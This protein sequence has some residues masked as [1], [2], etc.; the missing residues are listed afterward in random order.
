[1]LAKLF[2][3]IS[4]LV[5]VSFLSTTFAWSFGTSRASDVKPSQDEI[6]E[7]MKALTLSVRSADSDH[8]RKV[9][10]FSPESQSLP[11]ANV[12]GEVITVGTLAAELAS[13]HNSMAGDKNPESRSFESIIDRLITI[14]LVKQEALNIGFDRTKIFQQQMEEFALVTKIQQLLARQVA[15]LQVD[16][17]KVD[18]LYEQMAIEARTLTYKFNVRNDAEALLKKVSAGEDF[19]AVAELMISENKAEG[20]KDGQT[21]NR[22]NDL[23]PDVAKAVFDME[24]GSVSE[25][26]TADD[27]FLVFRLEDR[28][29]F[30]DPEIRRIAFQ[31]VF[32]QESTTV[33]REYLNS[34]IDTYA[35]FNDD[36]IKELDFARFSETK[37]GITNAEVF[38]LLRNDQTVLVNITNGVEEITITVANIIE[39]IEAGLFHGTDKELDANALNNQRIAIMKNKLTRTVGRFEA[40]KQKIDESPA[41]IELIEKQKEQ[42]L[43]DA[44]MSK[45]VIPEIRVLENEAKEYYYNHLE[46]YSSP[47]MLKMKSLV[48]TK[49]ADAKEAYQQLRKGS[50]FQWVSANATALATAEREGL[51]IFDK[52]L[53]AQN[54]L[55]DDLQHKVTGAKSGDI[56]LYSGPADLEYILIVEQAFPPEAKSYQQV[57]QDVGKIIYSRKINKA[58]D[59]YVSKLKEVYPTEIYLVR[60]NLEN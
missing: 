55:P 17:E 49:S 21:Y 11:V 37:P 58:L 48:F 13:M 53:L 24:I 27:G 33:Q 56:F 15:D 26:F 60:D 50:D 20:G 30:E 54:S 32:E 43:F 31:R 36:S 3:S 29:I 42:L 16:V 10:L 41:Y 45:A 6:T 47:L 9:E 19:K 35:E 12:N 34:L 57:R 25:I 40:E 8:I 28:R 18:K 5:V 38:D 59:D 46:D 7:G 14:K 39:E 1:M 2:H 51:L 23:F 4:L 44:F 22:L 52:T